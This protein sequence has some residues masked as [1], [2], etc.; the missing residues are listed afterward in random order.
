MYIMDSA[1]TQ[2]SSRKG[3]GKLKSKRRA[4]DSIYMAGTT[5]RAETVPLIQNVMRSGTRPRKSSLTLRNA[6]ARCIS[7]IRLKLRILGEGARDSLN[8]KGE[9]LSS[10]TWPWPPVAPQGVFEIS[11]L[12][13]G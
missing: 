2:D 12:V 6:P 4:L 3:Y 11:L 13:E 7:W 10:N 5:S 9:L 1:E 8:P